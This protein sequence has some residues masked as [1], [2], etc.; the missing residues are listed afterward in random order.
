VFDSGV[1]SIFASA[2]WTVDTHAR[3]YFKG[4][5]AYVIEVVMRNMGERHLSAPC[6]VGTFPITGRLSHNALDVT[7]ILHSSLD[8]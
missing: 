4:G 1:D 6:I 7:V 5:N 3:T 8:P 2:W